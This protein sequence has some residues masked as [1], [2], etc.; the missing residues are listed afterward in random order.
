MTAEKTMSWPAT[1]TDC[2]QLRITQSKIMD[3][4]KIRASVK[5]TQSLMLSE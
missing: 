4:E 1:M 2:V 5:M 3:G